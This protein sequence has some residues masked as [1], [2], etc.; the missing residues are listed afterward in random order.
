MT[1]TVFDW[2]IIGGYF[3]FNLAIGVYY[4][5]RAGR[6]TSASAPLVPGRGRFGRGSD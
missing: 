1:L 5:R 6:S 4:A 2:S 3:L